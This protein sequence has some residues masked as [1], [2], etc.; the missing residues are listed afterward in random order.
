M[1]F[2]I[3][4]ELNYQLNTIITFSD[5]IDMIKKRKTPI[6]VISITSLLITAFSYLDI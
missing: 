5:V 4:V 6:N 3:K 1:S 2:I